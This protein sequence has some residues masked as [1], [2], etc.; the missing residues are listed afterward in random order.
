MYTRMLTFHDRVRSVYG[1]VDAWEQE[2]ELTR[3][4]SLPPESMTLSCD[5]LQLNED[6]LG[7][8]AAAANPNNAAAKPMA[9]QMRANGNVQIQGE[10]LAQGQF[11]VQAD[12]ASYDKSKEMFILE[13]DMRTPAKL[14]RRT[15]TGDSPPYEARKIY[16]SRLTNQAKAEGI[17][18]LEI[19]P[20]DVEKARRQ[21]ATALPTR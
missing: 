8:R 5:E 20:G 12:R 4:D 11:R 19:N 17:Q 10:S 7:A 15:A 9:I 2:L 3:P 16:Y 21:P 6:P 14:W 1:P 13:G 18:Y